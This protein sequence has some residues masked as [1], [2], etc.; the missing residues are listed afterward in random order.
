MALTIVAAT[1]LDKAVAALDEIENWSNVSP[2]EAARKAVFAYVKAEAEEQ[3]LSGANVP[4]IQ[5]QLHGQVVWR[6]GD[7][8]DIP[9]VRDSAYSIRTLW[10]RQ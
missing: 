3:E 9:M 7:P 6:D 5:Y 1:C 2:V 8:R 10:Q 4:I